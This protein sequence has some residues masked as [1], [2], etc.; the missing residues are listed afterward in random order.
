MRKVMKKLIL[1]LAIVGSLT[2]TAQQRISLAG[3]WNF[4]LD[5]ARQFSPLSPLGHS[6]VLPG[7]TDQAGYGAKSERSDYGI[8]TRKFK[9]CGLAWYSKQIDIPACW[10]GKD[11]FLELERV[12]WQS[13]VF[14]DGRECST[15]ESLIAPHIHNLGRLSVGKHTVTIAIDNDQIYNIGDKGHLYTDYT[16]TI[17]NGAVGTIALVARPAERLGNPNVFTTVSPRTITI[18]DTIVCDKRFVDAELTFTLKELPSGDVVWQKRIRQSTPFV[19]YSATLDDNIKLWDDTDPNLYE[20]TVALNSSK[21]EDCYRTEVGFR[22]ITAVGNK[23]YINGRPLFLRGNL[24]CVHF[25]LTGYPAC[26]VESWERIFR[27]Y[28]DYGLNHVRFHSWTPPQAAFTAANRVGIYIQSEIIW[29]DWWMA[30]DQPDRP[31]MYTK[32][33]PDGLGKNPSADCFTQMELANLVRNY[34]NNPSF[35]M[36]CIGNELGNSDFDVLESWIKPYRQTDHRRLYASSTAR[37]INPSDQFAATHYIEELGSTRGLRGGAS[38]DW[39]FEDIYSK[40]LVPVIAHEIG[41]WPVYPRWSEIKKYRGTLSAMNLEEFALEARRNGVYDQNDDLV[42]ASGALSQ[43][44]YKYETES[45]LRT[46][47]ASGVQL[48]GMQDYQGQGEALVGW[49]DVFYD[50]KGITTPEK[51]KAHFDST[52][53]LL[54]LPKFV[55][56]SAEQLTTSLQL[57]HWGR[58]PLTDHIVWTVKDEHSRVVGSG[59]TAVRTFECGTSDIAGTIECDLSPVVKAQK[60]TIRAELAGSNVANSWD[61]WVYPPVANRPQPDNV[62]ITN[63]FDRTVV[64]WLQQGGDVLLDASELGDRQTSEQLNF[65][66][67]YWSLTFFPGQGKNTIGMLVD[68][69]HPLFN[70]FPTDN[71]SDWQWQ[72][73]FDNAKGFYINDYPATYRPIAQPVDDFH[74]NFFTA[75][76]FELKAGA[77]RL[78]VSGFRLADTA[79]V[80]VRQLRNSMLEY[81]AG[82]DFNPTFEVPVD[83]LQ[84][85]FCYVQTLPATLPVEFSGASLYIEAAANRTDEGDSEWSRESDRSTATEGFEY[86]VDCDGSW[87]DEVGTAWHSREMTLTVGCPKGITGSLYLFFHDW[88]NRGRA[89]QLSFEGRDFELDNCNG[90]GKWVKLHIMREDSNEGVLTLHI[91]TTAGGNT[92]LSKVALIEE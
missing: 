84:T 62:L 23:L 37:K 32:G 77:G 12:M 49:L 72:T 34:G 60:L 63:R 50:S 36:M 29:L 8:L 80:V 28:K 71:H 17:W 7:T 54:R 86:S 25:P 61:I 38:L 21:G 55:Y 15:E 16:Q 57:A 46:P 70:D 11:L 19:D 87:R 58:S 13:R 59:A 20:L 92:M 48:L 66:P 76:I 68:S 83:K 78:L 14:V 73:I 45:F 27:I 67:L 10:R 2:A 42:A 33:L 30:V 43:M 52:V 40:A 41:Q 81:M 26:D 35:V 56:T 44:M 4:E 65:Y 1:A 24:D 75:S 51:F 18:V 88:N 47:S 3:K 64:D 53:V 22:E 91:K 31:E 74:R 39:D 5:S 89:A 90:D 9:Y 82:D 85:T 69:S 6:I 79:N